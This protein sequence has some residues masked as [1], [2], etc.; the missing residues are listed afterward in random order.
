ML[1]FSLTSLLIGYTL[2]TLLALGCLAIAKS[3][4]LTRDL[5]VKLMLG[6]TVA[7]IPVALLSG[8]LLADG[9]SQQIQDDPKETLEHQVALVAPTPTATEAAL[10]ATPQ[11]ESDIALNQIPEDAQSTAEAPDALAKLTEKLREPAIRSIV[12]RTDRLVADGSVD[13]A[14]VW[15][16]NAITEPIQEPFSGAP[17]DTRM[18]QYFDKGRIEKRT[19]D[20]PADS[21]WPVTT[22]LLVTEMVTG[23]IQVGVGQYENR[24]PA[25]LPILG[26]QLTPDGPT[27]AMLGPLRGD[28]AGRIGAT[29]DQRLTA[30]GELETIDHLGEM[31]I[32]I[33]K[34]DLATRHGIAKPFWNYMTSSGPIWVDGEQREG[35]LFADPYFA[36]GHPITEP[37][38]IS[39]GEEGAERDVLMQCFQRRCLV[40]APDST[41][42]W[43][44][45]SNNAG[46]HYY[47]WRYGE[48]IGD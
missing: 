2:I 15:G 43:S 46:R 23:Q 19:S 7:L 3:R 42:R 24:G 10:T 27:Y 8:M 18:V 37:F 16:P 11:P 20:Q 44:V 6:G 28:R 30:D 26:T 40:Y 38:W 29:I 45:A 39:I 1:G 14:W 9:L 17:D 33:A 4:Q 36:T 22:G 31:R 47:T 34:L 32:T 13:R 21:G 41:A 12:E 25:Q 5:V 48:E 35:R